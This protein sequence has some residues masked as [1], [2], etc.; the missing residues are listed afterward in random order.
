MSNLT[1]EE[2]S[3]LKRISDRPE[4]QPYLFDQIKHLKWFDTLK[5]KGFF[6]V[7][8]KARKNNREAHSAV[9]KFM[10]NALHI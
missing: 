3:I 9:K 4:L 2:Q 7:Y 1:I 10:A 5:N 6:D 8:T